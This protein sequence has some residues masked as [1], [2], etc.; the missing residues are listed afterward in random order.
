MR[1]RVVVFLWIGRFSGDSDEELNLSHVVGMELEIQRNS[2][3]D[4]L[5]QLLPRYIHRLDV[6]FFARVRDS[7]FQPH[8]SVLVCKSTGQFDQ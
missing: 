7:H 4:I 6:P 8:E 3:G 1:Y 5:R 2:G